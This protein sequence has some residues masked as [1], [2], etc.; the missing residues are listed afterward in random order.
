[1]MLFTIKIFAAMNEKHTRMKIPNFCFASCGFQ[2]FSANLSVDHVPAH[3]NP[4][5]TWCFSFRNKST[6]IIPKTLDIKFNLPVSHNMVNTYG[7]HK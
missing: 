1:M 3:N 7:T 2:H 5:F 6:T 4:V